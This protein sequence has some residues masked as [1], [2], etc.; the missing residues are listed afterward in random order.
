M[1]TNGIGPPPD[2]D[3]RHPR[4]RRRRSPTDRHRRRPRRRRR[5]RRRHR[6][7]VRR[8]RLRRWRRIG[9]PPDRDRHRPRWRRRRSPTDRHRH[10]PRRRLRR[11][12]RHRH[13]L[14]RRRPARTG[15]GAWTCATLRRLRASRP[16]C[17]LPPPRRRPL[18]R[19]RLCGRG[20][21]RRGRG[22][23]GTA[24]AGALVGAAAQEGGQV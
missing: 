2:R 19:P 6:H 24:G 23:A 20:V 15:T 8:R 5:R 3:R 14:H 4:Q 22:E 17:F 21:V 11:R 7:C 12:R 1:V 10:H 18:L 9:P 16:T 13:C